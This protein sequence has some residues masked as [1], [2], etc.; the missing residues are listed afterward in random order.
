MDS[1][2]R[3]LCIALM[4]AAGT[5]QGQVLVSD[6]F[7]DGDRDNDGIAEGPVTDAGDVG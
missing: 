3:L 7:G 6:G 1:K 2:L 4:A 5:A